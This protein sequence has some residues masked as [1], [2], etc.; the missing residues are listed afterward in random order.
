M[1]D[2][3]TPT[4]FDAAARDLLLTQLPAIAFVPELDLVWLETPGV[5]AYLDFYRINF[6]K[7]RACVIHGFGALE[8]GG[9]R[10]ATHYWIPENPKGTLLVV[11]GY[12]DHVGLFGKAIE[13]GLAQG[14]AVLAFDL[15]GHGLSGGEQVAIDSFDQY[16]DVLDAVLLRAKSFLP[17]P[18]F[19]LGQSTGGAV[20]LNYLWRYD[21]PR[22]APVLQRIALCAPL[23]LPAAWRQSG[24]LL[25]KLLHH[26]TQRRPR[27]HSRNSHDPEFTRFIEERDC[28]QSPTLSVRWVGAMKAWDQQ[29]NTFPPLAKPVLVIQGTEDM[30]VDWKYNIQQLTGKLPQAEI[31]YIEGAGH[32]LVNESETY[33]QQVFTKLQEYFCKLP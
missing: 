18:F 9:F 21:A 30:T 3:N 32:Q 16:A 33:R 31:Y 7:T 10:I 24:R 29:F 17:A 11:H 2:N 15:P 25:Y 19:A 14:L 4:R 22:T 28:L 23:I 27:K 5:Q 12:Y 20:L 1:I 13:F 26:F 8:T 6:A